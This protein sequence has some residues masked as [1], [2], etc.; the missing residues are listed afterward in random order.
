MLVRD[1]D[2]NYEAVDFRESAPAA[3]FQDMYWGNVNGSIYGGLSVGVPSEVRG[4]EYIHSKYG[5]RPHSLLSFF[6]LIL[7]RYRLFHGNKSWLAPSMWHATA[8]KVSVDASSLDETSID[9]IFSY[10]GSCTIYG[11]H[12]WRQEVQFPSRR[13]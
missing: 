11:C 8:S 7:S 3:A 4:L 6:V 9:D 5:V 2:G 12:R 13:A 10:R 1:A